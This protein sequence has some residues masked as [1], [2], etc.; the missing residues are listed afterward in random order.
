MP[1]FD[2]PFAFQFK[3]NKPKFV[4]HSKGTGKMSFTPDGGETKRAQASAS[5][6]ASAQ[7]L[8]K[9]IERA[10]ELVNNKITQRLRNKLITKDSSSE[11]TIQFQSNSQDQSD[12]LELSTNSD[13]VGVL[14]RESNEFQIYT[15]PEKLP[16]TLKANILI[17]G[18]GG[19]GG[20]EAGQGGGGGGASVYIQ[21]AN[22]QLST[23]NVQTTYKV[24]YSFEGDVILTILGT[25]SFI[26]A[27]SGQS[28][29]STAPP[30][31][32]GLGGSPQDNWPKNEGI[33]TILNEGGNGGN[34]NPNPSDGY[35]STPS[36]NVTLPFFN[37]K[38]ITLG[39]GGGG[40]T[41]I[42]SSGTGNGCGEGGRGQGG[43]GATQSSIY[44]PSPVASLDTGY[45]GGG[46][47]FGGIGSD[48]ICMIWFENKAVSS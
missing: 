34:G 2:S 17:V 5:A 29:P 31:T 18:K 11:M 36:F 10:E 20:T 27:S 22:L 37:N 42:Q 23:D 43:L 46:G 26:A 38:K 12:P 8:Y 13:Y 24:M 30:N 32:G 1:H 33:I 35:E 15:Q 28:P 45:G 3:N 19:N 4:T 7:T 9:S 48:G 25:E 14:F 44:N 21:N 40:S 39:G 16:G 47:G 6:S 41:V